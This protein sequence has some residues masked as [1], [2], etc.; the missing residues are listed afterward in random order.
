[1]SR[2]QGEETG[3]RIRRLQADVR[4]LQSRVR[5]TRVLDAIEDV[6]TQVSS[7][8]QRVGDLRA[9][10]YVFERTLEDRAANLEQHWPPL[11][12]QVRRRLE[13][14]TALLRSDL[15][16]VEG[17]SQ[18]VETQAMQ[19]AGIEPL[20]HQ[21]ERAV[22]AVQDKAR[23][24]ADSI[25]GMYDEFAAQVRDLAQH[26]A[27][28]EWTLSQVSEASFNLLPVE[29]VIA[30][31]R[32]TW[33]RESEDSP[34]GV[35]FL[36]DQRLLFEQKQDIAT[37]K[38][39]FITTE[40][41]RVQQLRLDTPLSYVDTVLASRKGILGHEDHLD[42]A[43][44][45]QAEHRHAHFHIDGQRSEV[46]QEMVGRAQAGDYD[47]DRAVA[48]NEHVAE[49]ARAAPTRCPVCNAPITQAVLRGM[50]RITCE[51]CGHII[52]L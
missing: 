17:L 42:I 52:R 33:S 19:S 28:V 31:V 21:A 40:K 1:M 6:G 41:E 24:A 27:H 47:R 11:R 32:A 44:C 20:L 34:Q 35:L 38:I 3:R 18:E 13:Q 9:R 4:E 25:A 49:R 23:A 5:L 12:Q 2:N 16:T 29:G 10:G 43:F 7:L 50:D 48:I 39:L 26:L 46:W 8:R 22:E 51:Y 37:K 14:E 15:V 30:A 45:A 36:T